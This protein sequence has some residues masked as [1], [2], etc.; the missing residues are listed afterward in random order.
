[1]YL[2][3]KE[4]SCVRES[5]ANSA[6]DTTS[7]LPEKRANSARGV[8]HRSR[9]AGMHIE[10][11]KRRP[12]RRKIQGSGMPKSSPRNGLGKPGLAGMSSRRTK[13]LDPVDNMRSGPEAQ[14]ADALISAGQTVSPG[15]AVSRVLGTQGVVQ[16]RNE[17]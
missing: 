9:L 2:A 3:Q 10:E 8:S 4:R 5:T 16:K 12:S 15:A 17:R 1:M 14:I 6:T 13:K 11:A 7:T